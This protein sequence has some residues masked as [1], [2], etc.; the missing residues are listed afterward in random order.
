MFGLHETHPE[1]FNKNFPLINIDH[2]YLTNE[3]YG[4]VN[5][6]EDLP[7]SC[8]LLLKL[9]QALNWKIN[10]NI[11]TCL[12][13]GI[14]TDTGSLQHSNMDSQTFKDVAFLLRNK[15]NLESI[16]KNVFRTKSFSQLKLWGRV[17]SRVSTNSEKVSSSYV[18]LRDFN[19]TH[20]SINDLTGIVDYLNS[21]PNS[22]YSILLTEQESGKVK[23]SMRT[24]D[25]N[26]D[27]TKIAGL[28]GGGGHKKASGF[29]IKGK[30][31]TEFQ[32]RIENKNGLPENFLEKT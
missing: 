23:G 7:S 17:L 13:L 20:T 31:H 27:L 22:K 26:I 3:N 8:S 29:S 28:M 15:A 10:K 30:L 32:W 16:K 4:T 19:N 5:L 6:V 14:Y 21:I 18:N 11:S 9:F 2:H 25:D 24:L 1:I 12:M